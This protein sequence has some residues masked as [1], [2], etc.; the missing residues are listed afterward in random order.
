MNSEEKRILDV[1]TNATKEANPKSLVHVQ[2]GDIATI[3]RLAAAAQSGAT[4]T[5]KVDAK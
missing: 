4:S 2:A 1:L 5:V 3:C